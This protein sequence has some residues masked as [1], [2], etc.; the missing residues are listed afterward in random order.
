MVRKN[1]GSKIWLDEQVSDATS[2]G[3]RFGAL[4]P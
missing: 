1:E 2:L 3:A 4:E